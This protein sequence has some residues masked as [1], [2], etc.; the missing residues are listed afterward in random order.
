M[1]TVNVPEE[2]VQHLLGQT[3]GSAIER[4]QIAAAVRQRLMAAEAVPT[5][6]TTT[7]AAVQPVSDCAPQ[8]ISL[9]GIRGSTQSP[10]EFLARLETFCLV[11]SVAADKRLTHIVPAALEGSVKLWWQFVNSFASWEEFTAAF[12]AEFS[13]IDAKRRLKQELELRMQHPQ[14]NL[15]EFIY[16]IAVYYDRIG[17]EVPESEKVDRVQRQMRPQ[18]QALLEGRQFGGK[19][20]GGKAVVGG[21]TVQATTTSN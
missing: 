3:N 5:G 20:V 10:E 12:I 2:L 11:R 4:E 9:Q 7:A 6:S 8:E 1:E 15:K 21:N 16:T 13:F 14:E 17:G 19:A 18:L